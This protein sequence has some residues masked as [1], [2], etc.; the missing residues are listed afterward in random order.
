MQAQA[1]VITP[2]DTMTDPDEFING[3][4]F[5]LE[6]TPNYEEWL[7]TELKRAHDIYHINTITIYGLE[8]FDEAYKTCLFEN[9]KKLNMKVCVRIESYNAEV[10]AFTAKDADDVV[11]RYKELVEFTCRPENRDV[12]RYYALNM[13]VDDGKVQENLGGVNSEASKKNQVIYAEEIVKKMRA[14]TAEYGYTDAKMF[15]SV[16]FGWDATFDIPSY[17]SAKADGYFI[18]NY[19]Y[20][21]EGPMP[22]S[23][24]PEEDI[25]NAKR[26]A[27]S[28]NKFLTVY[29]EKPALVVETGFH[30]LEYNNGVMPNQTGGLVYDRAT[31]EIAAKAVL[32]FYKENY[33]NVVGL[34]YFGY[35]LYN[36]EGNPPAEMDWTLVY[37]S[38]TANEAEMAEP[39]G[40]AN[41]EEDQ[42]AS[43][44]Q[45]MALGKGGSA[46]FL[47]CPATQQIALTYRAEEKVVLQFVSR[48]EQKKEVTL[49][50]SEDYITYGIPLTL[51]EGYELEIV[52]A[53]GKISLDKVSFFNKMEAEYAFNAQGVH[54]KEMKEASNQMVAEKLTGREA[55]L[56]FTGV[57]GGETLLV[58]Y[59]AAKDTTVI[60]ERGGETFTVTFPAS[61]EL[62]EIELSFPVAKG[63]TLL[64]YTES[65]SDLVLD[66]VA[67]DGPPAVA[68]GAGDGED[69]NSHKD[70][71]NGGKAAAE[72]NMR[73]ILVAGG[74]GIVIAAVFVGGAVAF[75]RKKKKTDAEGTEN[76]EQ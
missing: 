3:A 18:N 61:R 43:S 59:A 56:E 27:N 4:T 15:L 48:N 26:L 40:N 32:R 63:D 46:K 34:L 8:G 33:P 64:L 71:E 2:Y 37:P 42:K 49:P 24:S 23:N 19:S 21:M 35:N 60:L 72:G 53:E 29:P 44:S 62:R 20:P 5:V 58:T 74:V 73:D 30:T 22:D 25:I 51:V 54:S 65:N 66:T 70:S 52:C 36:H 50:A 75:T 11:S 38:D 13:P 69:N 47:K 31:K 39:N 16:F 76:D 10:F 7:A 41:V 12:V 45:V 17:A 1:K 67:F 68:Q 28:M 6:N 57:R 14:L 9:L 55:A